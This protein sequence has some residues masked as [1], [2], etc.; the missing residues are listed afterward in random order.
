ME[1]GHGHRRQAGQACGVEGGRVVPG[2]GRRR[3]SLDPAAQSLAHHDWSGGSLD[4]VWEVQWEVWSSPPSL[5]HSTYMR[6]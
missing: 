1:G 3:A 5:P 2:L 4:P 6:G